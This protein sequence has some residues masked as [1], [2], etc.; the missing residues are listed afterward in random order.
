MRF[1]W[2]TVDGS[3][4]E[5]FFGS[6]PSV[7]SFRKITIQPEKKEPSLRSI[8]YPFCRASPEVLEVRLEIYRGTA[9]WDLMQ[10]V[11]E[12]LAQHDPEDPGRLIDLAYATRRAKLIEAA[13]AILLDAVKRFHRGVRLRIFAR[14]SPA[15][16]ER[17][18][19]E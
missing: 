3:H 17:R 12:K 15:Q 16:P 9:K 19:P 10:V 11:A 5:L 18:I 14:K 2:W 4:A 13:E 1:S 6:L 8:A 7:N